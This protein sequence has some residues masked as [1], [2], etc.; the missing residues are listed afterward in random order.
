MAVAF[1]LAA[2][3]LSACSGDSDNKDA[4]GTPEVKQVTLARASDTVLPARVTA[5]AEVLSPNRSELSTEA[6]A[7]VARVYADV[8][9]TIKKGER[10]LALDSTDYRLA[11]AQAEARVNAAKAKVALAE[12]RVDRIEELAA[13]GFA[14]DDEVLAAKTEWESMLAEV[15]VTAAD[16][17]VA[18]RAVD[19]CTIIAPFDGVIVERM[20]QLGTLAPAGTALVRLIDLSPAEVEAAVPGTDAAGLEGADE[21]VFE[22]QGNRFPVRLL[23]LAPV[24]D[25]A[26]RTRVARFA[27]IGERAQTGSSGTLSWRTRQYLLPA[28]LLVKRD[29]ALGYFTAENGVARFV[30]VDGAQPGRA[31]A[32]DLQNDALRETTI[33]VRGHQGLHDGDAIADA[34]RVQAGATQS[35]DSGSG[36]R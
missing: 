13:Q 16:R 26:A 20:A 4:A 9:S 12:R 21:L 18:A 34:S 1:T 23:R 27:F 11:L 2:S 14:S 3:F 22:S 36:A 24:V 17:D 19:S 6:T 30:A 33:V 7:R 8:G 35:G 15:Q 28:D 10:I 25:R 29:D 5:P 31:F 32:I